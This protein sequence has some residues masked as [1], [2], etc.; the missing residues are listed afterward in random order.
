MTP[1]DPYFVLVKSSVK[2]LMIHLLARHGAKNR[3]TRYSQTLSD[4]L[5]SLEARK[6]DE[7]LRN[8]L[9]TFFDRS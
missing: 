4:S 2:L 8:L 3:S 7:Q 1:P 5:V 6:L 9:A